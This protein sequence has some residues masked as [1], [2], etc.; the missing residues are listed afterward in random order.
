MSLNRDS[1]RV[2][3]GQIFVLHVW[4]INAKITFE[5]DFLSYRSQ[6]GAACDVSSFSV[7]HVER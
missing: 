7:S 4:E 5:M 2:Y 1:G 3:P 6:C